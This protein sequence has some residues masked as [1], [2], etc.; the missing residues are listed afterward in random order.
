MNSSSELLSFLSRTLELPPQT[1]TYL[2]YLS[3]ASFSTGV[4]FPSP[5]SFADLCFRDR[6]DAALTREAAEKVQRDQEEEGGRF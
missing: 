6:G 4:S 1:T 2:I 5:S 3:F